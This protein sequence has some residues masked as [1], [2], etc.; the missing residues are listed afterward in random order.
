MTPK[1][2]QVIHRTFAIVWND[3]REDYFDLEKLRRACP[4]AGCQG[5]G[6][7]LTPH[8]RHRKTTRRRALNYRDGNTSAGMAFNPG[9]RT[10]MPLESI[11]MPISGN[12][13]PPSDLRNGA[14]TP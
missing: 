2:I 5:E 14:L 4:C 6:N 1:N 12:W 3:S 10:V 9:G 7:V 13:N 11:H 8:D